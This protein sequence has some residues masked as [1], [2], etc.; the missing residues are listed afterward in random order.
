MKTLLFLLLLTAFSFSQNSLEFLSIIED[1]QGG[2]DGLFGVSAA[3]T[4]PDNKNVYVLGYDIHGFP[5]IT[6]FN[7]DISTGTLTYSA[8]IKNGHDGVDGLYG[9]GFV[10]VSPDNKNVYVASWSYDADTIFV[11]INNFPFTF[12]GSAIVVFN[13]DLITGA[14]TYSTCY[15][16]KELDDLFQV[17]VDWF[18]M[19]TSVTVSPDNKNIYITCSTQGNGNV[20]GIAIFNRDVS[21]GVLTYNTCFKD[22]QY[23]IDYRD[24]IRSVVLSPDNK[25]MYVAS[26]TTL[27]IFNRDASTGLL[28]YSVCLKNGYDGLEGLIDIKSITVSPD[29]KNVYVIGYATRLG[30]ALVVFDR[31]TI[32][33]ELT[34]SR[35]F[36]NGQDGVNGLQNATSVIVSPDNMNVYVIGYATSKGPKGTIV[37]FN[38]DIST[39]ALTYNKYFEYQEG[40]GDWFGLATSLSVSPDNKSVYVPGI[41]TNGSGIADCFAVFN[42]DITSVSLTYSKC[43][44]SGVDGLY[45]ARSVAV[46]P[47]NKNVYVAS[48]GDN[49]LTIF[50]RDAVTGV[51]TYD[52]CIKNIQDGA[53]G[54]SDMS[55]LTISPDN[56]NV[57]VIGYGNGGTLLVFNR[58]VTTGALT[59]STCFK[60]GYAN[61][62]GLHYAISIAVSPDNKNVYAIGETET[63]EGTLVVFNRNVTTGALTYNTCF[64]DGHDGVDGLHKVTSVIVSPDNMNVYVSGS[65]GTDGAIAI[66]NRDTSTGSLTY[67]A[68][69]KES[70]TKNGYRVSSIIVSPDNKNVYITDD[71]GIVMILDRNVLTGTLTYRDCVKDDVNGVDG[72]A[73]ASSVVVS[74]DNNMVF[75]A[76]SSDTAVAIFNRNTS[77]GAL[78]YNS[79]YKFRLDGDASFFGATSVIVS[80][81]NQNVYVT[82]SYA[83]AIATFKINNDTRSEFNSHML[84]QSTNLL[85]SSSSQS[86]KI[87]FSTKASGKVKL[88]LYNVQG[89]LLQNILNNHVN[90]GVHIV[91]ANLPALQS[92]TYFLRLTNGSNCQAAKILV[93]R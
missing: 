75:V 44:K 33:G 39:G 62:D 9:G 73:G 41:L 77:T 18:G 12:C 30:R 51:L 19:P 58:D 4:S 57:Y 34:Y 28:T 50:S 1:G 20:D 29:N 55:A 74:P 63:S 40:D 25:N 61:V 8:C 53:F 54:L 84:Q 91:N 13:R 2:L 93:I 69:F 83:N 36:K 22:S 66:F 27:Y 38:R 70:L 81:D 11:G 37:V 52:T 49:A 32:T 35:C 26:D 10:T 31:D 59:Y 16:Y 79:C 47:D 5:A 23:Y 86:C 17:P 7:Q 87:T 89:K 45:G 56:K 65:V 67:N 21:D 6:V 24:H 76:G 80:P 71:A 42:R 68:C 92:G 72:I 43:F 78:I 48:S 90:A 14:L 85:V 46:S 82:G 88:S 3:T 15:K 60:D 64:K